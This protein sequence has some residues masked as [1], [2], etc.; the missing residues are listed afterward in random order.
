MSKISKL[1][2]FV[3]ML[4]YAS[5]FNGIGGKIR[6]SVEDFVV[7][8]VLNNEGLIKCEGRYPIFLMVK[9][10]VDT[11]HACKIIR[12]KLKVMPIFLG[13]KDAQSISYQYIYFKRNVLLKDERISRSVELKPIGYSSISL[14]KR[15]LLGNH[16]EIWIRNVGVN[17]EE[18]KKVMKNLMRL[19]NKNSIP[20]FFGYQRFGSKRPVTHLIGRHIVKRNFKEAINS[21]LNFTWLHEPEEAKR[22][23]ELCR[24]G[25]YSKALEVMPKSLDVERMILKKILKGYDEIALLR[26]L[27]IRLRRLFVEA[28]QSYIFNRSLSLVVNSKVDLSS[29]EKDDIIV[30][31]DEPFKVKRA[32][33]YE[34]GY[35]IAMPIIGYSTRF[36]EGRFDKFIK[37]VLNEENVEPKDF[38]VKEMQ[39]VSAE[40][41]FRVPCLNVKDFFYEISNKDVKVK[42]MLYKGSYATILLREIIKPKEPFLS[43]F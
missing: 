29:F 35:T 43:G 36:N 20:N 33:G 28:Y 19:I 38:Y 4:C 34:Q 18:V 23:R 7:K 24:K 12:D 26:S 37:K 5:K 41:G 30:R 6:Q 10:N 11:I 25:E 39:E 3:G 8:E 22:A 17:E 16:F 9:R 27:P 14:G 40:G 42:F 31:L 2:E 32:K 15:H 13:M 21:L 1:D